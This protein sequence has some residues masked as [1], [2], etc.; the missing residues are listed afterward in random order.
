M[1][2]IK[3]GY[4][5]VS[6]DPVSAIEQGVLAEKAGFDAAWLP[7]HFVDV[8][9]DK[10]EP[11]TVLAAISMK[12]KRIRLGSAVTDTQRSH[13]SRTAHAVAS[14]DMISGGRAVL[15]IGAGE[16]MNIVPY[17]LPWDSPSGRVTRLEEAIR[18]IQ[19]LWGSSR[20][21]AVSFQGTC[22]QLKEAF[23]SQPPKQKPHPPI[24][25]GAFS[26]RSALQVVGRLGNGW[27]AWLNTPDTFKER[28]RVI[29]DAA[30]A[31]GR[32]ADEIEPASH[33][34]MAFPR[35]SAERKEALKAAKVT[36]VMEKTILKSFGRKSTVAHY[37]RLGVL[38][39]DVTE[40]LKAAHEVPDDLVEQ[41]M[42]IGGIEEV[43]EKIDSLSK[44]GVRHFAFADFLAPRSARRTLKIFRRI[45]GHYR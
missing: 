40:I 6:S 27:Y 35:N 22:F 2:R 45:I 8:D 10:L 38:P 32:S 28:W 30:N 11:W 19:L 12:T 31:S 4:V 14:L 24:F 33:I 25:V 44:A 1:A 20:K 36:L 34:M 42:A 21:Q 37:Q 3:F 15:G 17:G 41:T 13:P 9:G 29:S 5:I 16:A 39:S 18:V 23:L 7:D 26:S 43:E